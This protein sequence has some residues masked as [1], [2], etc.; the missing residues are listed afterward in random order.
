MDRTEEITEAVRLFQK[1]F[2][3][4]IEA[5]NY[6]Y[7]HY[8][9]P[10][11]METPVIYSYS[12]KKMVG[13]YG[14]LRQEMQKD[15]EKFGG[16]YCCDVAIDPE[17]K[18]G[19]YFKLLSDVLHQCSTQASFIVMQRPSPVHGMILEK[20]GFQNAGKVCFMELK[21]TDY[22]SGGQAASI[23]TD[24]PAVEIATEFPFREDDMKE[25]EK[26]VSVGVHR[27]KTFFKWKVDQNRYRKMIYCVLRRRNRFEGYFIIE[28]D[29]KVLQIVDWIL[30]THADKTAFQTLLE[31]CFEAFPEVKSV[32]IKCVN[33]ENGEKDAL[34]KM[35][36]A[37]TKYQD[38]YWLAL[39]NEKRTLSLKEWTIRELD[40]DGMLQKLNK[41]ERH[42]FV[43]P[44]Y[45]DAV[46]ACGARIHDL[47]MQG[48]DIMVTTV[49]GGVNEGVLSEYAQKLHR[50]WGI[51]SNSQREREDEEACKVLHCKRM[52]MPFLDAIYRKG[53]D[54]RFLYGTSD[55]LFQEIQAEDDQLAKELL[56]VFL[57]Q[58]A[59]G[60]VFY[61][62]MACGN[63]VDHRIVSLVGSKLAD[64]G[65]RVIFYK[66][67]FYKP[68]KDIMAN[69]STVYE[70]SETAL[71]QKLEAIMKYRSQLPV[72]YRKQLGESL[73][74]DLIREYSD[75]ATGKCVERY[76]CC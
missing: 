38:V 23:E 39:G 74:N 50:K 2:G 31:Y 17:H 44:H 47:V 29:G 22:C 61:F 7:K 37:A 67:F 20:I 43:S 18:N 5:G 71:S 11:K 62:P 64:K 14:C 63:H 19:V 21:K 28:T 49:F 51:T 45:D 30:S 57:E 25:I 10:Y 34:D 15:G 3:K 4:K 32:K 73:K 42:I 76:K 65:Y 55:S 40:E 72:L 66:E 56:E 9:N 33:P 54:G 75:P 24:N 27:T 13:M 69:D 1:V 35:G 60:D 26:A 52:A 36:F 68:Q 53:L 46:G 70:V 58:Y 48:K 16:V 8:E 41:T 12:D 59:E 6:Y